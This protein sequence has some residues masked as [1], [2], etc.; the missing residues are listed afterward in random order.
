M[1]IIRNITDPRALAIVLEQAEA[2]LAAEAHP[3]PYRG[4][5]F[6]LD[7]CSTYLLPSYT[8]LSYPLFCIFTDI[9]SRPHRMVPNGE[10]ISMFT[11]M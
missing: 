1:L 9:Q 3:D 5:C 8:L 11:S 2:K 10:L 6:R 4:M 7:Y